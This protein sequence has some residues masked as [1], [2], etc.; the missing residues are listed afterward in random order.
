MFRY[1]SYF[2]EDVLAKRPYIKKEWC[3]RVVSA[4]KHV[5]QQSDGRLRFWGRIPEFGGRYLRVVTLENQTTILNA[6][7]DRSFKG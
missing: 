6:F 3:E 5:E 4:R 2:E 7:F 1:A